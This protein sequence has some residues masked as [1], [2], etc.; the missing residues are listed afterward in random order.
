[1]GGGGGEGVRGPGT[2][3]DVHHGLAIQ[4]YLQLP[5]HV[6]RPQGGLQRAGVGGGE[7]EGFGPLLLLGEG[8]EGG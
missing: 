7:L 6:P 8:F 4:H 5:D 3:D 1:M 2:G